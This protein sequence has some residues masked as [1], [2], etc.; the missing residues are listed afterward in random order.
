MTLNIQNGSAYF[1]IALIIWDKLFKSGPSKICGGHPLKKF[2]WST[3]EYFVPF[4]CSYEIQ[5]SFCLRVCGG[6]R[7]WKT[8][9]SAL[10]TDAKPQY[11]C[12][13]YGQMHYR[14]FDGKIFKFSGGLCPYILLTDCRKDRS[15]GFCDLANAN[16]NVRA[17]NL[18]CTDTYDAYMCKEV[19]VDVRLNSGEMVEII[20]MQNK[21]KWKTQ[22]GSQ[23]GEFDKGSYPQPRTA[24]I[25]GIEIFKVN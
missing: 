10:E 14:T 19:T 21:V 17:R 22:S 15:G 11:D 3:L 6:D 7:T 24:V 18:R 1:V 16:I 4:Y 5:L 2:T 13:A 23:S 8:A 20:L 25:D 12:A 9:E